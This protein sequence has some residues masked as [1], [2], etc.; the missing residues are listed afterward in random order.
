MEAR[1]S[2][3]TTLELLYQAD[4]RPPKELTLSLGV[5]FAVLSSAAPS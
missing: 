1:R 2:D 3:E 5:Q 4:E